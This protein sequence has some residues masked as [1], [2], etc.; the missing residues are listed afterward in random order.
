VNILVLLASAAMIMPTFSARTATSAITN[1]FFSLKAGLIM[2]YA[3][4]EDGQP[5]RE[6]V[7]VLSRTTVVD[8]VK[9]TTVRDT[10]Y[11]NGRL[12]ERA[13]DWYAQDSSGNVWYLGEDSR[14]FKD[15]RVVET[16]GSWAAGKNGAAPGI[17]MPAHPRVGDR[18]R[19]EYAPKIAEDQ[20]QVT[21]LNSIVNVPYGRFSTTVVTRD[22]STL[23]PGAQ[24]FKVYAKGV[25]LVRSYSNDGSTDLL[26]VSMR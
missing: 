8:S 20:A 23:E 17:M 2:V 5:A 7:S 18:Y 16:A 21:A 22:F 9:V 26:L 25:G 6:V 12:A 14:A 1:E 13:D 19:Q 3:G 4:K 15:G 24:E 11:I 10:V